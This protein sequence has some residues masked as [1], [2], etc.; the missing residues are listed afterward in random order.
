[1][2][3]SRLET[4]RHWKCSILELFK[5]TVYVQGIK[6]SIFIF[7][8]KNELFAVIFQAKKRPNSKRVNSR[9]EIGKNLYAPDV[10]MDNMLMRM[11]PTGAICA[12]NIAREKVALLHEGCAL[13][14]FRL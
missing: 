12:G 8:H 14:V 1:M 13:L 3:N 7:L 6:F 11:Q 2:E 9:R 10:N 5:V 4:S